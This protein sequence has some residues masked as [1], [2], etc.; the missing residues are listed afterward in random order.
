M[1]IV[2]GSPLIGVQLLNLGP[3][4]DKRYSTATEAIDKAIKLK[5]SGHASCT[6]GPPTPVKN[7]SPPVY[8]VNWLGK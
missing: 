2:K 4:A 5:Y 1:Y 7:T 3:W 6:F 8:A